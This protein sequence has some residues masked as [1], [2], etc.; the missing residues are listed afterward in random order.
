M[1]LIWFILAAYGLT[2]ILVFGSIFNPIRPTA[3]KLGELFHCPLCTGFWVGVFLW[4]LNGATELFNFEY[5]LI[6]AFICGCVSS[7]TSY[8]L[9]MLLDD[10]GLKVNRGGDSQ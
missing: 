7:G 8:F 10:F 1:E 9:S 6:N 5:N 4:S 3:G 2:F